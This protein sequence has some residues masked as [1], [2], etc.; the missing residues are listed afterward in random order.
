[1]T[2]LKKYIFPSVSRK[3]LEN[4]LNN[5]SFLDLNLLTFDRNCWLH[6]EVQS[7]Y[8]GNKNSLS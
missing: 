7:F 4:E 6:I 2:S 8:L 3:N 1:M 5:V